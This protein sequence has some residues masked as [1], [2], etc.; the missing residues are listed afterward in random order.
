MVSSAFAS[1]ILIPEDTSLDV[2]RFTFAN[3]GEQEDTASLSAGTIA[4]A[5][6]LFSCSFDSNAMRTLLQ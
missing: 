1:L 6:S 2:C 3:T 5:E 4:V